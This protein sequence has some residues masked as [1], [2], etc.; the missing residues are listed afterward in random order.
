[1]KRLIIIWAFLD[2]CLLTAGVLSI[3]SAIQFSKPEHLILSLIRSK[4]NFHLIGITLGS[5]YI[6]GF[7]LSIPAILYSINNS[8]LLKL[9][10]VWLVAIATLTL[11]FASYIWF[12]S[13]QQINN[14]YKIWLNQNISVH[15]SIQDEFKCC[16]YF[17][18]TSSGGFKTPLGFCEDPSFAV[19]QIGCQSFI[20]SSKSPGS[21]YTLENIFTTIYGFEFIIGFCFLATVCIINERQTVVRFKRI[22]EKRGGGGFV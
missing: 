13:L 15:Q 2:F 16:G 9:L 14:F 17:N 19:N 5:A 4:I 7:I 3:V 8:S 1:M 10:N 6:F 22:D 11:G 12:F 18:G 21:D 20:T